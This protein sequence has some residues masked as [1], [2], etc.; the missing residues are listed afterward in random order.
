MKINELFQQPQPYSLIQ[1]DDSKVYKFSAGDQTYKVTIYP[2]YFL[3]TKREIDMVFGD[4]AFEKIG[5]PVEYAELYFS[6]SDV[7]RENYTMRMTGKGNQYVVFSTVW[8]IIQDTFIDNPEMPDVLRFSAEAGEQSRIKLYQHILKRFQTKY[9]TSIDGTRF[10][11]SGEIFYWVVFK[12]PGQLNE[13][14]K[15]EEITQFRQEYKSRFGQETNPRELA[16]RTHS[17]RDDLT[18]IKNVP[19]KLLRK[20]GFERTGQGHAAVVYTHPEY[21]YVLKLFQKDDGYITWYNFCKKNQDNPYIPKFRGNLVKITPGWYAA[22]IEKLQPANIEQFSKIQPYIDKEMSI[23]A[24]DQPEELKP[25]IKKIR[26]F[27]YRE[28]RLGLVIDLPVDNIMMRS[29]QI[30]IIDP[31]VR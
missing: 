23:Q 15:P 29:N 28:D 24:L 27:L 14:H 4:G 12:Q 9:H 2:N 17:K 8:Q 20:Y 26:D 6:M 1:D 19:D 21:P 3:E 13:L 5:G 7:G 18:Y 22:R 16:V 31:L 10:G 11:L 30:V 25:Y